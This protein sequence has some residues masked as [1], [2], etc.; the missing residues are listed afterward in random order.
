MFRF[1]SLKVAKVIFSI[2]FSQG[3]IMF[4]VAKPAPP[5]GAVIYPASRFGFNAVTGTCHSVFL[6][7]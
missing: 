7:W 1:A 6:N 4:A 2:F 3:C 5:L